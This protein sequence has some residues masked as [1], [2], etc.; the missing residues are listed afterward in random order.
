MEALQ[1]I[2]NTLKPLLQKYQPPLVARRDEAGYFN[3]WSL[4]E[5]VIEGY[6]KKEV[7]FSG[8]IIHK[9]YVGFYFMPV[10]TDAELKKIF[11]P[12]LLK[13]LKGKSCFHFNNLDE[14]LIQQVKAALKIGFDLYQ[15]KGWV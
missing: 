7:F 8:L 14:K 3:L 4:K 9:R 6:K 11:E 5:V 10:Y 2:F 12:E 1:E 13:L 15:Q